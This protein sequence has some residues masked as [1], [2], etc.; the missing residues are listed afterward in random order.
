MCPSHA[1]NPVEISS[2]S[3]RP[4]SYLLV[5]SIRWDAYLLRELAREFHERLAGA[6]LRAVRL[7]GASRDL[8]MLFRDRTLLWRL[9]PDRGYLRFSEALEPEPTDL[10]LRARVRGV[11]APLDE[12]IIRFTLVPERGRG[13]V[14]DLV[15]ELIGN[16]W[17]ALI[18]EAP[19]SVIRHVLT[20]REGVRPLLV[21]Q[22]YAP[23][24]SMGRSDEADIEVWLGVLGETP[25]AE[26]ARVLVKS[27]AWT[28]PM[29]APA[30]LGLAATS[31]DEELLRT[32]HIRWRAIADGDVVEPVLLEAG[33][34]LQPYPCKLSGATTRPADSLV[35]GLVSCGDEA[36]AGGDAP[37]ALTLPP[38]VMSAL[39]GTVRQHERRVHRLR[40]E[41]REIEDS[42]ALRGIGDL[43]LSRYSE[44][45]TGREEV[46]LTDFDGNQVRV[47]LDPSALPNENADRY[48]ERAG[49]ADRAAERLP[50]L[51]E[52]AQQV[53]ARFETLHERAVAGDADAA[54]VRAA[55]P[56]APAKGSRSLALPSLPYR[57]FRSSGGLEIRVGR[58]SR[59]NDDLTF[60]HSAP[61]DVWL[62][63]RHTAGA[64]VVLRWSG[65]GAPP[66][67]DLAEAAALAALHSKART[68]GS[69][70]V[71]WTYR[72][73]VRK[74][75]GAPPGS[76]APS[77]VKTVFAV[78]DPTLL[79]TLAAGD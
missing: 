44:I 13:G 54:E 19:H 22:P 3:R 12:R 55:L 1:E 20:R 60:R 51:I 37:A 46:S 35:E 56:D 66:A 18:V 11:A 53:L 70:P 45:G 77:R 36:E 69:V 6:R 79:D 30:I 38:D 26:R 39:D 34:G 24:P 52:E 9:H 16:R 31:S 4:G 17:N 57:I 67:R 49:K 27:F 64:H 78:P 48:Y 58:G 14:M 8:V 41:L 5:M 73:Y 43:I 32:A 50:R 21:G 74:P 72:K 63:A 7:D 71:D 40:A 42:E 10:R 23:P 65:Q 76:V 29:N 33:H 2:P 25:P 68:S 62:H 61:N 47:E 59:H 28:S 15:V 75:R